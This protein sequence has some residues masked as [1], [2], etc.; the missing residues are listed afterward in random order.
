MAEMV[1]GGQLCSSTTLRLAMF[2]YL[3]LFRLDMPLLH[4]VN[5][6]IV[7]RFG[8]GSPANRF[9]QTEIM[10][11]ALVTVMDDVNW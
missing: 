6:L 5:S 10:P 8:S 2:K 9:V 11:T 3:S 1:P 4:V 7:H